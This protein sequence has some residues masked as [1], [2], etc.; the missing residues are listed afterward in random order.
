LDSAG[1]PAEVTALEL[2][3][4]ST[5]EIPAKATTAADAR[6]STDARCAAAELPRGA[7]AAGLTGSTDASPLPICRAN[8]RK[9]IQLANV[10]FDGN[11]ICRRNPARQQEHG[12]YQ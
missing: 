7:H 3:A 6:C 10:D 1:R 12:H 4:H 11:V 9:K 8:F 5:A 2:A